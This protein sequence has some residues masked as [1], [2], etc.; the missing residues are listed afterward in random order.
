MAAT[1]VKV[2]IVHVS[3]RYDDKTKAGKGTWKFDAKVLQVGTN[4]TT[5]LGDPTAEFE[6]DVWDQLQLDWDE[7]IKLDP[8]D[9]GLKIT[10]KASDSAGAAVVGLGEIE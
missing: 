1:K 2:K 6:V 7:D 3:W 8:T 4:K 5:Q 10:M 9:T